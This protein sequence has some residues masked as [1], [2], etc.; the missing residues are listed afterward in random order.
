MSLSL[1]L[2]PSDRSEWWDSSILL[3]LPCSR[4]QG[5]DVC[6]F[7]SEWSQDHQQPL[8]VWVQGPHVSTPFAYTCDF[9]SLSSCSYQRYM[10]LIISPSSQVD[11]HPDWTLTAGLP[12]ASPETLRPHYGCLW[13]PLVCIWRCCWQ[14]SAQRTALLRCGLSVLGGDPPQHG[15][16]GTDLMDLQR[17]VSIDNGSG[18]MISQ[19]CFVARLNYKNL[20]YKNLLVLSYHPYCTIH[21]FM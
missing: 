1:P 18:W 4:M 6:V 15:Q 13:P 7:W 2:C 21:C 9:L 14:H 17:A 5:Q 11:S 19:M 16:W 12:S 3:Q 8:S 10:G 20:N